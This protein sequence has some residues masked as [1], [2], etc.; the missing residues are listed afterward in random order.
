MKCVHDQDCLHGMRRCLNGECQ[1]LQPYNA[2]HLCEHDDDCAHKGYY[3]PEDATGD[4]NPYW[5]QYCRQQKTEGEMCLADRE[6]LPDHRC[7]LAESAPRCRR[8][9]SLPI[10]EYASEQYL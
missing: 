8:L 5:V 6:C 10:G 4:Q 9:F 2:S 3:C 7:N 1:P